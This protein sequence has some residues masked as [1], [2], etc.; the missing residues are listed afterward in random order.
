MGIKCSNWTF[1]QNDH[2]H[3][4]SLQRSLTEIGSTLNDRW[5]TP[6]FGLYCYSILE[7]NPWRVRVDN[8]RTPSTNNFQGSAKPY[9]V[10]NGWNFS[11]WSARAKKRL[12]PLPGK[13]DWVLQTLTALADTQSSAV[14]QG[15]EGRALCEIPSLRWDGLWVFPFHAHTGGTPSGGSRYDQ[16][17]FFGRQAR[18]GTGQSR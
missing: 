13:Q 14:N 2:K 1:N 3:R 15:R 4:S 8:L 7:V 18:Y 16:A 12:K 17:S 10:P 9:R 6:W 5:H 11:I